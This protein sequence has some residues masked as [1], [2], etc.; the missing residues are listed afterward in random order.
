MSNIPFSL[1]KRKDSTF[2]YVRF[3]IESGKYSTAI[4]TKQ[5]DKKQAEKTA[6]EW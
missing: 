3:K 2:Y 6:W 4:S 5:T 1:S